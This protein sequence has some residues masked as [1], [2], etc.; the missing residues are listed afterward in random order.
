MLF[1]TRQPFNRYQ[2]PIQGT[3][4]NTTLP[5]KFSPAKLLGGKG[6]NNVSKTLDGVQQVLNMV[7]TGAPLVQEYGPMIKN[8]PA[9]YRMMKAFNEIEKSDEEVANTNPVQRP[10]ANENKPDKPVQPIKKTKDDG[11][12]KPKL[13]I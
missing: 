13:F 5:S 10:E 7:Q 12:P 3:A 1:P 11:V 2:Q 4:R 9:M 8:L 6:L